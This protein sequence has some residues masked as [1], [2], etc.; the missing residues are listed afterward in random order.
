MRG[1]PY[2][3]ALALGKRRSL[4]LA[5]LVV[6]LSATAAAALADEIRLKDG[7]KLYGVIVAYEDNMF[8]VKTDYGYVLVEKDKIASIVPSPPASETPKTDKTPVAKKNPAA[9]AEPR[10]EPAV[11]SS[12]EGTTAATNASAKSAETAAVGNREKAVPKITSTAV[13][14]EVP[15]ATKT[16]A[17]PPAV[18]TPAAAPASSLA[19]SAAQPAA[20]K[21]P[22]PP[23]IRENI[24]GN[25]YTNY[26]HGFK[27]YKAPS[28]ELIEEARKALPNAIVALGTY[29]QTTLMVIGQE[30]N[31]A[32]LEPSAATVEKRLS[33]VYDNYRRISQR[34]TLVGG[35]PAVEYHYRGLADG[36]DWSGTLV[37]ISRGTDVF[38]V[39]GM[40]YAD[41]DLIQ[42]QE[43]VINRSIASLDFNVH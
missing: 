37:V 32:A 31:K 33:E 25:L 13:K 23:A 28:W 7:K 24:Q 3:R 1:S 29:N 40:T 43:N 42:I 34:K 6:A 8:K 21:E 10:A 36:H 22:E 2:V 35:L 12:T 26:T 39:L 18:T 20:P 9:N 30:Q 17:E 27:M 11:A 41:N 15:V 19:E 14:P 5:A 4:C 16:N 38:T